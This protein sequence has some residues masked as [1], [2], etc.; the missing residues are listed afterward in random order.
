MAFSNS[1]DEQTAIFVC[2]QNF[3]LQN[4]V[5]RR[6]IL[7]LLNNFEENKDNIKQVFLGDWLLSGTNIDADKNAALTWYKKAADHGYEPA[8]NR[9]IALC[10]NNCMDYLLEKWKDKWWSRDNFL[11]AFFEDNEIEVPH[12]K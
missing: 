5:D 10:Q 3:Y 12:F 11:E 1:N 6:Y 8:R 9:I 4:A 2:N 7:N